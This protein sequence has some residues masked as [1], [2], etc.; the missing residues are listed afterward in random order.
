[1]CRRTPES[2]WG[3][4]STHLVSASR[5]VLD[6]KTV[7]RA[8]AADSRWILTALRYLRDSYPW[9]LDPNYTGTGTGTIAVDP[10]NNN[11]AMTLSYGIPIPCHSQLLQRVHLASHLRID[12]H[13]PQKLPSRLSRKLEPVPST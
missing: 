13:R 6:E 11:A 10:A 12:H 8:P 7:I 4:A 1:M 2:T 9:D 5:I 3:T